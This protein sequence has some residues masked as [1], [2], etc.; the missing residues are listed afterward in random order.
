MEGSSKRGGGAK[1]RG[2]GTKKNPVRPK[3]YQNQSFVLP[4]QPHQFHPQTYQTQPHT[5]D[6]LLEDN[7]L[8]HLLANAYREPQQSLDEEEE[9]EEE[10]EENDDVQEIVPTVRQHWTSEEEVSLVNAYLHISESKK[11]ANEQR[12]ETFWRRVINHFVRLPGAKQRNM[13]QMT[14]KW[15]DL[16][17]KIKPKPTKWSERGDNHAISHR[18]VLPTVQ[19]E[20]FSTRGGWEI[21]RN[22][23]KWVPVA[24]VDMRGPTAPK[25]RGGSKRSKTSDSGNYTTSASDNLPQMNLNDDPLDEPDQPI[26]DPVEEDTPTRPRRKKSGESSSKG[27]EAVAESIFRI[28]EEKM[29]QFKKAEQRKETMMSLKVEREQAYKEHLK[30]IERQNDLKI[31]RENHAHLDEPFKSIVIQQKREICAK[32]GW[33]MPPV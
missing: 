6:P 10:E 27:K 26:D 3:T 18:R 16:N 4:F 29:T 7:T 22:H 2:S 28:E 9:E 20:G 21:A 13:D 17:G 30:T 32:W 12:K 1:K 31:L 8:I 11:H 14:S 33:E 15:T 5:L 25:K 19:K 24:L 23:P